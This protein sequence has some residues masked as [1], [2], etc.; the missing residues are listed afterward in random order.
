MQVE[1]T[2]EIRSAVER[3]FLKDPD[4]FAAYLHADAGLMR[5]LIRVA[6]MTAN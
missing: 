3:A 1:R 4:E 2:G 5:D 6:N